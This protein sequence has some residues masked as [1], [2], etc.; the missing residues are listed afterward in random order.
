MTI[1]DK[2]HRYAEQ[3]LKALRR[4][5]LRCETDLR[6][7][8]IGYKIREQTLAR[9]PFLLIIGDAEENAARVTVRDRTG[10]CMGTLLLNEAADCIEMCCRPPE[11][12]L[13]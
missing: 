5:G 6:N 9:I 12:R 1:T 3:V 11:V 8:K 10:K 4:K 2:Q 7:E 13:D